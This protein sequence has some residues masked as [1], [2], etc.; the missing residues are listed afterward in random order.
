MKSIR[1][2]SSVRFLL[3]TIVPTLFLLSPLT[4]TVISAAVKTIPAAAAATPATTTGISA[5]TTSAIAAPSP[6]N[7]NCIS[8]D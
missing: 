8:Y 7:A 5:N 4:D 2:P 3:F 1:S 6:S